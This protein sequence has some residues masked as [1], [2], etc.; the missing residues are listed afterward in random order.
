MSKNKLLIPFPK[1]LLET[2]FLERPQRFLAEMLLPNGE[3]TMA[4]CANPG[5]FDGCLQKGSKAIVWDSQNPKRKRRYTWKAIKI[6]RTWVGTDTQIANDIMAQVLN[7][8]IFEHFNGYDKIEQEVLISPGVK[9]DFVL[10]GNKGSCFIEVKSATVVKN[11]TARFPDSITPRA[12]KHIKALTDKA[13]EG[14]KAVQVFI[15]Q[16]NDAKYF[17][18]NNDFF[19]AYT[20]AFQKALHAGVEILAIAVTINSKAL[21]L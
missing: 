5:S 2:V 17:S 12:L 13:I 7:K 1:P 10:T 19:P 14:E 20:E 15:V 3:K 11:D 21:V 18:I 8:K 6:G 4:Y 9:V 16:R